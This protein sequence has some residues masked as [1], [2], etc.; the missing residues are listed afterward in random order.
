MNLII[1]N[2]MKYIFFTLVIT[3][4]F[5]QPTFAMDVPKQNLD[6][7]LIE[8]ARNRDAATCKSL[9]DAKANPNSYNRRGMHVLHVAIK[10]QSK[11]ELQIIS[12][13]PAD[14]PDNEIN[15]LPICMLLLAEKADVDAKNQNPR[16]CWSPLELAAQE[17]NFKICK[18]LLERGAIEK[19]TALFTAAANENSQICN[20]LLAHGANPSGKPKHD[21]SLLMHATKE[22][23]L[24][25]CKQLIA[26]SADINAQSDKKHATALMIAVNKNN[27]AIAQLLL[28]EGA[29]IDAKTIEGET[30]LT[31]IA[32]NQ[33]LNTQ[34][35]KMLIADSQ[36]NPLIPQAELPVTYNRILAALCVFNR[37]CA[38]LPKDVRIW[39]LM[40]DPELR[41]DFCSIAAPIHRN[42]HQ[43]TPYMPIPTI[44]TL[45]QEG[46]LNPQATVAALKEHKGKILIPLMQ[47]AREQAMESCIQS[48]R[49][50]K[51]AIPDELKPVAQSMIDSFISKDPITNPITDEFYAKIK[52]NQKTFQL[53]LKAILETQETLTL[54]KYLDPAALETN[55]G[56][57]I[58]QNIQRRLFKPNSMENNE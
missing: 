51:K 45:L 44:C 43:R 39:I 23:H 47:E 22:G 56:A 33:S 3:I 14:D 4:S 58:E 15:K 17:N 31:I 16:Y 40:I 37:V 24:P 34:F 13:N 26:L 9:L 53:L 29:Q 6:A 42:K 27:D 57:A 55:F 30:A 35:C 10:R 32:K 41:Q 19:D 25:L 49:D 50:S 21:Y 38:N 48:L 54:Y 2:F 11:N 12:S 20:L 8:A 28:N 7:Q 52:K 5:A 46:L 18:L 1:G 36:I